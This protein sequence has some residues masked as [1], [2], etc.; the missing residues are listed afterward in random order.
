MYISFFRMLHL[1]LTPEEAFKPF[2]PIQN[3]IY[4]YR[5]A[6]TAP[7]VF[8]LKII[9]CLRAVRLA[10]E[11]NWYDPNTFDSPQWSFY[12]QI[13]N[14]DMNWI[15]PGK[16]LAFA[17]PYSMKVLPSGDQVSTPETVIPIF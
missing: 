7:S 4:D 3:Y 14:G 16:L 5:D 2:I 10:M 15:I 11:L 9:D 6:S 17:S 12:E 8:E 1:N 13:Q